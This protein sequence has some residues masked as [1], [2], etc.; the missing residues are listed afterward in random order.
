MNLILEF[1]M[2]FEET[3]Q[4][5]EDMLKIKAI[6][7]NECVGFTFKLLLKWISARAQF[8]KVT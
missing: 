4:W 5:L 7:V 3:E 1:K 2:C 6:M 8:C